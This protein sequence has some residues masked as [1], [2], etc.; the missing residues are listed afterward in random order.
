MTQQADQSSTL[1]AIRTWAGV[2]QTSRPAGTQEFHNEYM[3]QWSVGGSM[4]TPE[5]DR[6]RYIAERDSNVYTP[7]HYSVAGLCWQLQLGLGGRGDNDRLVLSPTLYQTVKRQLESM[8]AEVPQQTLGQLQQARGPQGPQGLHANTVDATFAILSIAYNARGETNQP[9]GCAFEVVGHMIPGSHAVSPI[10]A[11]DRYILCGLERAV[12]GSFELLR[13]QYRQIYTARYTERA[14]LGDPGYRLH[15]AG[16]TLLALIKSLQ[17]LKAQVPQLPD[18]QGFRLVDI[19]AS[20]AIAAP[21]YPTVDI[22]NDRDLAAVCEA[23]TSR[24][25]WACQDFGQPLPSATPPETGGEWLAARLWVAYQAAGRTSEARTFMAG[26]DGR[27]QLL[28]SMFYADSRW[29]ADQSGYELAYRGEFEDAA[30][31][32]TRAWPDDNL[33]EA[34]DGLPCALFRQALY[35]TASR[36][37]CMLF[38]AIF[39]VEDLWETGLTWTEP[40][41]FP[42]MPCVGEVWGDPDNPKTWVW[43]EELND[44]GQFRHA[45]FALDYDVMPPADPRSIYNRPNFRRIFPPPEAVPQ[46]L[47]VTSTRI[48][49]LRNTLQSDPSA[50]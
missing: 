34:V 41:H 47:V 14:Y 33:M 23:V 25:V 15:V 18:W 40:E 38:H 50:D 24:I 10:F 48:V 31:Y 11:M 37:V 32:R 42:G 16:L 44:D 1:D 21:S 8:L 20:R 22:Q 46:N 27:R 13:P 19:A 36:A 28:E 7:L 29:V 35:D 3:Q 9:A 2:A 45:C 26:V 4:I 49:R 43:L 17:T 30:G 6:Y 39:V 12:T 5:Q